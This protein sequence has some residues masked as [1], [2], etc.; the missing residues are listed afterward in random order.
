MRMSV[1]TTWWVSDELTWRRLLRRSS[2]MS[3]VSL[4]MGTR[5]TF[6]NDFSV[7]SASGSSCHSWNK[8]EKELR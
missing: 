3:T 2:V 1:G 7:L 5:K 4:G 6:S 8:V